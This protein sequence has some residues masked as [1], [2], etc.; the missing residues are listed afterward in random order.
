VLHVTVL[1]EADILILRNDAS[2]RGVS[3]VLC[4][5]NPDQK[6]SQRP[7]AFYSAQLREP[8]QDIQQLNWKQFH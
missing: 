7:V 8:R 1:G 5:V 2:K 4:A 6:D 3:C